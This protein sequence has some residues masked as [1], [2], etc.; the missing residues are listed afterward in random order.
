M[1]YTIELNN[2]QRDVDTRVKS[3]SKAVEIFSALVS[4]KDTQNF[5]K[6]VDTVVNHVKELSSRAQQGDS[7][8]KAEINS[9]VRFAIQPAL[10]TRIDLFEFMGKF[11]KIGYAEQAL[12]IEYKH[13]TRSSRQAAQGDVPLSTLEKVERPLATHTISGGFAV[14]YREIASGNLNGVA[15]GIEQVKVDIHNK[16]MHYVMTTLYNE[17]K[18]ATGVKYFAEADGITKSA[19]DDVLRKVR[20]NGKPG[21]V[22]DYSVVSQLNG[23]QGYADGAPN[24]YS[25]AALEEIRNTGL[26]G[27]YGGSAVMEVPNQYDRQQLNEAGDNYETQLPEGLLF[28]I[29]QGNNGRYPLQI[30]QRGDLMSA[31]GFDVITG[32]ELTRFDLEIG[33]GVTSPDAIGLLSD[34]NFDAPTE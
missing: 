25:D 18:N 7:I 19:L 12:L 23:F 30:V 33:A 9:F 6:N 17:I 21:I 20:R 8:A 1:K 15:E 13:N 22:G 2:V 31:T 28:V 16:A 3:T 14:N 32:S 29:P 34:T 5:G 27:M 24:G 26:L 11:N 10:Q 4:G